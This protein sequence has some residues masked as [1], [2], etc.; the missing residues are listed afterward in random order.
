MVW[1][2]TKPG[3]SKELLQNLFNG[4][5]ELRKIPGVVSVDYGKVILT[6]VISS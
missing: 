6:K 5:N 4:M 1:L 3:I 2:K